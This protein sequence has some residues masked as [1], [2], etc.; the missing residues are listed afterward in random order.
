MT[1]FSKSQVINNLRDK[2]EAL[3]E[4]KKNSEIQEKAYRDFIDTVR[5]KVEEWDKVHQKDKHA[6]SS[7]LVDLEK[8]F[9]P[10]EVEK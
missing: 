3:E 10:L 5:A 4:Y 1:M 9:N 2:V 6:A 7:I 8:L